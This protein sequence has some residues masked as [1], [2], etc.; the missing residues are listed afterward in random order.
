M[1]VKLHAGHSMTIYI[2]IFG[3][4]KFGR[5]RLTSETMIN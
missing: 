4:Q 3:G 1:R 5:D 2:L